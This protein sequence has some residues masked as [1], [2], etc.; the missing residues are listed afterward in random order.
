VVHDVDDL[1]GGFDESKSSEVVGHGL[2]RSRET[3]R[4]QSSFPRRDGERVRRDEQCGSPGEEVGKVDRRRDLRL[5]SEET[6]EERTCSSSRSKTKKRKRRLTF[7]G[8][9]VV[10]WSG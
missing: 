1:V 10:I 6:R 2:R 4:D 3:R 5:E 7:P 9:A 8:K